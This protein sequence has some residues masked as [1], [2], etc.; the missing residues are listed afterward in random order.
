MTSLDNCDN[1]F[2]RRYFRLPPKE[3]G[4]LRFLLEGYD[5]LAFLRTIDGRQALVEVS[6][7]PSLAKETVPLLAALE[8]EVGLTEIP[9]PAEV[10]EDSL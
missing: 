4:Y 9:P 1:V 3:V 6:Y 2:H 10:V 5:G 8:A 7:A